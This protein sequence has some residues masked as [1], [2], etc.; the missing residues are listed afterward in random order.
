MMAG[1][2]RQG[3]AD[4]PGQIAQGA[5][6]VGHFRQNPPRP[7]QQQGSGFGQAHGAAQPVEQAD[8]Q[9][10]LQRRHPFAD[11]GLGYMQAVGSGRKRTVVGDGNKGVQT[12][13][14][15]NIRL[16]GSG[17]SIPVFYRFNKKYEFVLSKITL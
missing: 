14:V 7:W 12:G 4:H 3:A 17:F 10:L 11:S 8:V 2:Q 5:A 1:G 16:S 15:H 13:D 6:T 9:F